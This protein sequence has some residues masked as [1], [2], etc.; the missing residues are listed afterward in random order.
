LKSKMKPYMFGLIGTILFIVFLILLQQTFWPDAWQQL[1][2]FFHSFKEL[3]HSVEDLREFILS[4]GI[5]SPVVF[6]L[7]QV[8]QVVLAPIPGGAVVVAGGYIFGTITGL[9]LCLG[10]ALVGS[11]IVF[12]LGRHW[13]R[14]LVIK[15]VGQKLFDK[16]IGLFDKNGLLLFIIFLL[17]YLPDDAVCAL[18]GLSKISLRRF[19]LLVIVGRV[20]SM[21]VTILITNGLFQGSFLLWICIGTVLL[22]LLGIAFFYRNRLESWILSKKPNRY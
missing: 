5:W 11:V 17:P 22:I 19:I 16:Y 7:L 4:F 3:F 1:I 21:L 20:P 9:L 14:P 15:L 6:F 12:L 2:H 18:A 13:G 8:L 10:G